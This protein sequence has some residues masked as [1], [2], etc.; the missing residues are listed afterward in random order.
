MSSLSN[1]AWSP[2]A[3]IAGGTAHSSAAPAATG[4]NGSVL[5]I[6]KGTS[7]DH[8]EEATLSANGDWSSAG[9][10]GPATP[11]A[12]TVAYPGGIFY[13]VAWTSEKDRVS[14]A[15]LSLFGWGKAYGYPATTKSS[16]ALTVDGS[17]VYLAWRN[18][19]TGQVD[20][21]SSTASSDFKAWTTGQPPVPGSRTGTAPELAVLGPTLTASWSGTSRGGW[22]AGS[23][24]PN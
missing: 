2:A 14:F 12:P 1:G 15:T 7:K 21:A 17:R 6:W 16:P 4:A 3:P 8:I 24:Q 9:G 20:I 18:A 19:K 10:L 22:Y 11:D 13:L 23:D 5:A